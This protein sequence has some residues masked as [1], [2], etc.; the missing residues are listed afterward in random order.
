[1]GTQTK[2]LSAARA[3]IYIEDAKT[4]QMR[5]AGVFNHTSHGVDYDLIPVYVNGKFGPAELVYAGVAP[6]SVSLSGFRVVDN[7]PYE[8]ANAPQLQDLLKS[9][10][11][12]LTLVD[13][14][15]DETI[16]TVIGCK[17]SNWQSAG[18]ARGLYDLT[19]NIQGLTLEDESGPQDDP[20]STVFG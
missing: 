6:I 1:M 10:D 20:G 16:L 17:V 4:G 15:T 2:S 7:G 5:L 8:I 12:T 9:N 14:Q 3:K 13:R 18:G 11:F 19:V